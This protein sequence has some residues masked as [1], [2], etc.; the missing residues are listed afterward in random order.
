MLK[1]AELGRELSKQ[2][3]EAAV[4]DLR[5]SLL[6]VQAQLEDAKFPVVVVISGAD[7][8]GKSE[9]LNTLNEWFDARFLRNQAYDTPSEAARDR[10]EFWRYWMWQPKA[11]QIALFLGS[12]YTQPILD[13][14]MS[15]SKP[16]HFEQA[17]ARINA[18]ERTLADGGTLFIKLWFHVSKKLQKKRLKEEERSPSTRFLV[19]KSNWRH[20]EHYDRFV[21]V[22]EQVLRDTSTGHAPWTV[23]EST[24]DRYRNVTAGLVILEQIQR[25]LATRRVSDPPK[26]QPEI[27]DPVTLLDRLDLS[28]KLDKTTYEK[29]MSELQGE[30]GGLARKLRKR[31]RSAIILFEGSDAAGKGG[32]I[33]RLVWSLDARQYRIIPIAAPTEEE[34][35]HHYLWRFFRHVPPRGHITIYDRSWYGRVLVERVEGFASEEAWSRAYKEINDFEQ[36]LTRDGIVLVKFWLQ[37]SPEEQLRRFQAREQQPWKQ[38]KITAED[39]RNRAKTHLYE[40][41][42]S[43]MIARNSTDYAPFTLVEAEDKHHARIK[44]LDTVRDRLEKAL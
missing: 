30:I 18:F 5:T 4:A 10:P 28:L 37:I 32:A 26:A 38:H 29:R 11:G 35:A 24:D 20:H 43:E 9:T 36:E 33:R 31:K 16:R 34:R 22:A 12:W 14:V 3:Y 6:K 42:A 21:S 2:D 40:A 1:A 7:G 8:A 27:A 39:Y 23:I 41:A 17:L 25:H 15:G 44:V 19:T 13:H